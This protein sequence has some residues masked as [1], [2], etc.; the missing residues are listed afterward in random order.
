MIENMYW[1]WISRMKY[2]TFECFDLLIK[3]YGKIQKLWNITKD[4]LIT[5]SF[6]NI[7]V[8]KEI[9]CRDYKQDL[10][11]HM[12][13]IIK[14]DI[15]IINCYSKDYPLKLKFIENRPI[16]L[17]AIG[18]LGCINNESVAIVGSRMATKYGM[19]NANFF[20]SELAKRKINVVS[21]LARGIDA[22]SHSSCI[23]VGGK[24]IAVVGHRPRYDLPTRKHTLS[25]QNN[26]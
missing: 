13:Y 12:S 14:H 20:S 10:Q 26:K 2:L 3:K 15:K 17:Y 22:A 9:L 8:M 21:G 16:V 11:K 7:N 4:E 1:I 24:T 19:K 25:E 23:E 5:N 18:D 6:C